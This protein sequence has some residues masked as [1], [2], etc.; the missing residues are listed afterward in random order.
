[1]IVFELKTDKFKSEHLG[2]VEFYLKALDSDV[3][4]TNETL[5][6]GYYSVK[7]RIMVT[8]HRKRCLNQI[9]LTNKKLHLEFEVRFF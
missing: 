3:K 7:E 4:L 5:V 2:Q 8:K 1:L 6:L 9:L